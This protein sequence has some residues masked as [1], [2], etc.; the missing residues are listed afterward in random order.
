[1]ANEVTGWT[2][3]KGSVGEKISDEAIIY[4]SKSCFRVVRNGAN[5]VQT[6]SE[7]TGLSEKDSREVIDKYKDEQ[8]EY[9]R[10][11]REFDTGYKRYYED[12]ND[13]DAAYKEAKNAY[14]TKV[15]FNVKMG[16]EDDPTEQDLY[17]EMIKA[18]KKRSEKEKIVQDYVVDFKSKWGQSTTLKAAVTPQP[19]I[20]KAQE[21]LEDE[22]DELTTKL[23]KMNLSYSATAGVVAWFD[24]VEQYLDSMP[25][26][27][28]EANILYEVEK[29]GVNWI[30]TGVSSVPDPEFNK[31]MREFK[32]SQC[33][34]LNNL[35]AGVT[36]KVEAATNAIMQKIAPFMPMTAA[37]NI[38]K[39][40]LSLDTLVKFGTAVFDF[41]NAQ[42]QMVVKIYKNTMQILE[43]I[44]VR[45][46]Q[47]ISKIMDKVT[48]LDCPVEVK[49]IHV[50]VDPGSVGSKLPWNKNK[51]TDNL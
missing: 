25:Q 3:T 41:C 36:A 50:S 12:Y 29:Q 14:E 22:L 37:I 23:N 18:E 7:I 31:R 16:V 28:E 20:I 46:P 4:S 33:Q 44:V 30:Y 51:G 13:A 27:K 47:L 1:M 26:F 21:E 39:G 42:Y 48:E 35:L 2:F 11:K 45:F 17:K 6:V 19:P 15:A 32:Q 40:G 9:E 8:R 34:K 49:S 43:L 24:A 10:A 5:P 38:I